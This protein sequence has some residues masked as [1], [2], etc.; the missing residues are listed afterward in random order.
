MKQF[1]RNC[2]VL[3]SFILL[4]A[5]VLVFSFRFKIDPINSMFRANFSRGRTTQEFFRLF[6][7]GD[8]RF[9]L[10]KSVDRIL[11]IE[12]KPILSQV[13][14]AELPTLFQP[15]TRSGNK[16]TVTSEATPV[17]TEDKNMFSEKELTDLMKTILTQHKGFDVYIFVVGKMEESPT[18]TGIT[19]GER[20]FV[21]F[22]DRIRE[23]SE[24]QDVREKIERTTFL[25]EFGHLLGFAHVT[26]ENC[27]MSE[28]I[29]SPGKNWA[30]FQV[31][32]TY[33]NEQLETLYD[34][35]Q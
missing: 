35:Q 18:Y 19:Y 31:P 6:D 15:Y 23:L 9:Q 24:V 25:H 27:L 29:H 30:M 17:S 34:L 21:I 22:V 28:I 20:S 14:K 12:Q 5:S 33:C 26:D 2:V 13:T 8:A 10:A 1:L 16:A 3:V 11:L 4:A 32:T 7:E